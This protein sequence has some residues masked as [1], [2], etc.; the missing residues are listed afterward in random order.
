MS[1]CFQLGGFKLPFVVNGLAM[2][3]VAI[4]IAYILPPIYTE[5]K[6]EQAEGKS[7]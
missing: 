1:F 2:L 5:V 7:N 4:F 3:I 6:K